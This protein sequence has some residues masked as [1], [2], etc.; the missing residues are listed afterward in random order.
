MML[1]GISMLLTECIS[2]HNS[3]DEPIDDSMKTILLTMIILEA[4]GLQEL[5]GYFIVQY[6][7]CVP[8]ALNDRP[9]TWS[10]LIEFQGS[11]DFCH[12]Y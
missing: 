9:E 1:I 4:T 12:K 5:Q 6:C 8:I 2:G 3:K 7:M 10:S 11:E